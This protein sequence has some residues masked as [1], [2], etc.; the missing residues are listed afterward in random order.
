MHPIRLFLAPLAVVAMSC[1]GP[2]LTGPEDASLGPREPVFGAG[3]GPVVHRASL[4]GADVCEA[5]GAP[6]GCDANFSLIAQEHA[7]GT[8]SGQWQDTFADGGEG[9]HVAVDCLNVVGNGAV[10]S[11]VV[12]HGVDNNGVD[13]SG[14][15]VITAVVDNGTSANDPPD[16]MSFSLIDIGLVCTDLDPID[17]GNFG[18]LFDLTHGQVTVF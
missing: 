12:T 18:F 10:V 2:D 11:G 17:V 15:P 13:V 3:R 5:L 4:G 1:S 7:D 14:L 9:I 6:T 8:V 16:Q